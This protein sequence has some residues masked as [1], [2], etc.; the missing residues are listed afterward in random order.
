MFAHLNEIMERQL[1]HLVRLV[2][3]LLD[4]SRITRGQI[5][6]RKERLDL[7]KVVESALETSRPLIETGNHQLSVVLPSEAA[8]VMGDLTRLA[9]VVA[10]LLNNSAK[11]TPPEGQISLCVERRDGEAVIRVRDNGVGIPAE[12]LPKVFDMFTQAERTRERAQGGLGIGLTLVRRLVELHTGRV[13]AFSGGD[14]QGS[15]FVVHLPLAPENVRV[16]QVDGTNHRPSLTD[17]PPLRVLVVDDNHD[18]LISLAMLLRMSG[19]EVCTAADGTSALEAAKAFH[20]EVVLLDVG[21]PGMNGY[22]VGRRMRE[23]PETKGAV[24][25]AQTGWGQDEDRRRSAEAGFDAHLV[26]PVDPAA[27]QR[28]LSSVTNR[29]TAADGRC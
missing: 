8:Y 17:R 29:P 1:G 6:L 26:K 23:M 14:N 10:N 28:I 4:V 3:D 19:N 24:L 21:L 15:E 13:E 9:Q 12:M 18:S 2:D 25:V 7:A 20:P 22:E 11:Y 16:D 27:L 5:E